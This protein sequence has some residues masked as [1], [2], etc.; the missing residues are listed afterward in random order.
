MAD[1]EFVTA[2]AERATSMDG[3][4][5]HVPVI[6]GVGLGVK[7]GRVVSVGITVS[8]GDGIG[9][10]TVGVGTAS[11]AL[12]HALCTKRNRIRVTIR[13]GCEKENSL[14]GFRV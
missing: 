2:C 8:A 4:S 1:S 11:V 10:V 13:R 6:V 7:E 5:V 14:V 9:W 3:S 12:L